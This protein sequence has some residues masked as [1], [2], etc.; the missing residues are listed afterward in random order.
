MMVNTSEI[1]SIVKEISQEYGIWIPLPLKIVKTHSAYARLSGLRRKR[2]EVSTDLLLLLKKNVANKDH[3]KTILV[4]EL[5]HYLL[6]WVDKFI[7]SYLIA[8]ITTTT[9]LF[10]FT[11]IGNIVLIILVFLI[12]SIIFARMLVFLSEY[13]AD[14]AASLI[15]GPEKV[16]EAYR[17]IYSKKAAKV[18]RKEIGKKLVLYKLLSKIKHLTYPSSKKKIEMLEK[19]RKFIVK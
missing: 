4:H 2:I 17:A 8:L 12:F 18:L 6:K 1:H 9:A 11:I 3:V 19:Y 13:M 16:M 5:S 14:F 7:I 15:L 10:F